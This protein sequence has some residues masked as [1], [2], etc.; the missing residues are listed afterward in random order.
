METNYPKEKKDFF[1]AGLADRPDSSRWL[2]DL[3]RGVAG[4]RNG[5]DLGIFLRW[6][7]AAT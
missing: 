5:L 7:P 4:G 3:M 6:L 1:S 2:L